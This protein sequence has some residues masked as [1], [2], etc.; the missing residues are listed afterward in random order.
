MDNDRKTIVASNIS[1]GAAVKPRP[2]AGIA[3]Q[4]ERFSPREIET[5]LKS[6]RRI[7]LE[8]RIRF[9]FTMSDNRLP[10]RT[11]ERSVVLDELHKSRS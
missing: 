10:R 11:Q 5:P 2:Q 6:K 9:L 8:S 4:A 1:G 7:R 3:N